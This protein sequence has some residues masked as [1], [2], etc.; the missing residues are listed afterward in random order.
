MASDNKYSKNVYL[1]FGTER[2][3]VLEKDKDI[4][5]TFAPPQGME[6]MNTSVYKDGVSAQHLKADCEML[7]FMTEKRLIRVVD[8][9]FF[10]RGKKDE[11]DAFADYVKNIPQST[12]LVFVEN[13]VQKNNALYKAVKKH[14]ECME[15]EPLKAR[16]LTAF[17]KKQG[18]GLIADPDYFISYVGEDMEK[19]V[20]EIAKLSA[21]SKGAPVDNAVIDEVCS[22]ALDTYVFNMT[23]AIGKKDIGTAL[24][25]Y[26]NMLRAKE[27]PTV[28]LGQIERQF[29][30]MLECKELERKG[31]SRADI[32][33]I[34]GIR[35]FAARRCMEQGRN[36]KLSEL[37]KGIKSCYKCDMDIKTGKISDT[38][39]VELVILGLNKI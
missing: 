6:I 32:A 39:G 7:P 34:L 36:F 26:G 17:V 5:D 9:G 37:L 2:Y 19:L 21:Y 28:I 10:T 23:A 24:D 14:G 12:V 38:L 20:G 25:I 35:E 18:K 8:S 27:A 30:L 13:N 3:L 29:K 16:E 22:P 31:K 15:F 1:L 4:A 33:E 11:T